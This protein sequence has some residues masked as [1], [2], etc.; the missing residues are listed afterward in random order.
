M[1]SGNVESVKQ[2]LKNVTNKQNKHFND[3]LRMYFLE[4]F[5]YRL[6]ISK[7]K[8][9]FVLKGGMLLYAIFDE[10]YERV[11]SDIDLLAQKIDNDAKT[12]IRIIKDIWYL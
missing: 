2:R 12:F 6:S 10:N 9:N 4:R 3:V 1:R 5:L 7:Y 11:T 8:N